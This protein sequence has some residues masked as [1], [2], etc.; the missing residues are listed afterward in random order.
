MTS[1]D[2]VK[3]TGM[4]SVIWNV[5]LFTLFFPLLL[6]LLSKHKLLCLPFTTEYIVWDCRFFMA[7]G[8]CIFLR[9]VFNSCSISI[10]F[11]LNDLPY[12]ESPATAQP[13]CLSNYATVDVVSRQCDRDEVAGSNSLFFFFLLIWSALRSFPLP[14]WCWWS[15]ATCCWCLFWRLVLRVLVVGRYKRTRFRLWWN[16][17]VFIPEWINKALWDKSSEEEIESNS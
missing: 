1:R 10:P 3:N 9:F 14:W 13:P 8:C 11:V 2:I 5:V 15:D 12:V 16:P 17:N 6:L 4:T 7:Y